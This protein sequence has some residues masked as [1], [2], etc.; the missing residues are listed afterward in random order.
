MKRIIW[1][2]FLLWLIPFIVGFCAFPLKKSNV[3]LFETIM[4][5]TL[6]LCVVFFSI[7]L[8]RKQEI[9]PEDRF[10]TRPGHR[11]PDRIA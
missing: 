10:I 11:V 9:Y 1:Y 6:S 8:Y 7:L 4:P 3:P 5:V 2:G